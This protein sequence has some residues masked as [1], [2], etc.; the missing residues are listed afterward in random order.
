M[1]ISYESI[2]FLGG[3]VIVGIWQ[4]WELALGESAKAFFIPLLLVMGIFLLIPKAL[5]I[6]H[7]KNKRTAEDIVIR[8]LENALPKDSAE[9]KEK[10]A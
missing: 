4:L 1:K 2:C 6:V 5:N 7:A 9:S 8:D 3:L 10:T